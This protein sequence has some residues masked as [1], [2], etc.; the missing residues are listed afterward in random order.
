MVPVYKPRTNQESATNWDR[1]YATEA[2]RNDLQAAYEQQPFVQILLRFLSPGQSILDSGCGRGGLLTFLHNRGFRV[3]GVDT[4]RE[5][6]AFVRRSTPTIE[7]TVASIERLPFPDASFDAYVAIGSWEYPPHGPATAA[8]EAAR[9][10]TPGGLL[11]IEVPRANLLR[12][13]TYIPLKRLEHVLRRVQH[14]PMVFAHHLFA[15]KDIR[16]VLERNGCEILETHP[17][18]LPER[19]RH[20]GLWVDW[21]FLRGGSHYTLNVLGRG[22]KAIGNF[23]SPWTIAT[24]MFTVARKRS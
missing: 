14:A 13:C 12:R 3:T 21:P 9:V 24:G 1:K 15:T 8:R 7:A 22:A 18:D 4:S 10:L 20:Y 17:H 5:A 23:L 6:I 16:T 11:F 2:L 19:D